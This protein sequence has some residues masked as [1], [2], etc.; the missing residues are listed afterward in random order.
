MVGPGE[1]QWAIATRYA[2]NTEKHQWLRQARRVS[3]LAATDHQLHA[4]QM[5]CVV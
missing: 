1:T 5:M 4:N 2:G 3:G